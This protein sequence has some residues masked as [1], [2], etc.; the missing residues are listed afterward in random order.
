MD[1]S[2]SSLVVSG[3]RIHPRAMGRYKFWLSHPCGE[4]GL[5]PRDKIPAIRIQPKAEFL[6]ASS[7][8]SAIQWFQNLVERE[9][10]PIV[11][12]ASRLDIFADFQGWSLCAEDRER[13]VCRADDIVTREIGRTFTGFEI[14]RRKTNTIMCRIYDKTVQTKPVGFGYLLDIWGEQFDPGRGS[15]ELNLKSIE[16]DSGN[17]EHSRLLTRSRWPLGSG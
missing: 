13:F 8:F 15:C 1:R 11:M 14:G 4:I 10:G 12:T 6:H 9:V 3:S 5:S 16:Q 2:T 17:L 7:P